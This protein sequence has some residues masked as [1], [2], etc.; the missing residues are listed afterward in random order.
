MVSA[1]LVLFLAGRLCSREHFHGADSCIDV[2]GNI[3]SMNACKIDHK[4][5]I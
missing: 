3:M 2:F 1:G 5:I 4:V